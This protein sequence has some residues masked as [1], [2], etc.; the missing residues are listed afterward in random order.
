MAVCVRALCITN[1]CL[2]RC[3]CKLP[4][5]NSHTCPRPNKP[6][7]AE[8]VIR[9]LKELKARQKLP[10]LIPYLPL[11]SLLF[12]FFSSCP[13][14]PP[15]FPLPSPTLLFPLHSPFLLLFNPLSNPVLSLQH[16]S[17]TAFARAHTRACCVLSVF[18]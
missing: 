18:V 15:F 8:T 12:F 14:R 7:S 1:A 9:Q 3:V 17:K 16:K 6:T 11:L 4:T 5:H 10:P 13:T 2:S